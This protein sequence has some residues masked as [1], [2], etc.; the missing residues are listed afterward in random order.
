MQQGEKNRFVSYQEKNANP[1]IIQA[2]ICGILLRN[3]LH[4][5][6]DVS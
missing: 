6:L 2:E 3:T 4:H 5:I 1:N